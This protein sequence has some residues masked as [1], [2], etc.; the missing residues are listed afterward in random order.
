MEQLRAATASIRAAGLP[1]ICTLL[2]QAINKK[3]RSSL[4]PPVE[5][6]TTSITFPSPRRPDRT[7][8]K[9]TFPFPPTRPAGALGLGSD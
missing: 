6:G 3:V 5:V 2:S 7:A 9:A 8:Q 4:Q 1:A